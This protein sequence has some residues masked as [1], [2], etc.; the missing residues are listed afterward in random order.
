MG[1]NCGIVGLPNVGKSTL[2]NAL[3][4][5]GADAANY[6]F[7]TID[8]NVGVVTVPDSRLEAL[9]GIYRPQG[10]V[11]TTIEF[12]DIAGLVKGA[13]TGEGLGNKFLSHIRNV[14]AV[15][16][17]VRCF[18]DPDVVHV[19]GRVDPK[20]DIEIVEAELIFKDLETVEKKMT[21]TEKRAR[22]GDKK[23]RAEYDFYSRLKDHLLQAGLA[24]HLAIADE[25]ERFWMRD[26]HLLTNKP[27]MYVCNIPEQEMTVSNSYVSE[28]RRAAKQKNASVVVVS[29]AIEAE[30]AE[31]P[32]EERP[33]FLKGLGQRE[34]GLQKLIRE[35][36]ALLRLVT[37]FTAGSKE[38]HA[39]TVGEGTRA[40]EAAGVVH[41]DFERGFIR[42]EIMKSE[43]LVRMGSEQKVRDHGLL[44]VEGK[45]YSIKDGDVIYFR[46]NV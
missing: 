10:V 23:S 21:D 12:V 45:E 42:A 26:M 44:R 17:V 18:D 27:V 25:P 19:T 22:A 16:H 33:E 13:S 39:W 43:D 14:D 38:V 37:F 36:Y 7:C 3:T 46:F 2:F 41:T 29:A 30:V 20:R 32:V 11:P 9:A 40:P 6:P 1:F 15:A 24:Q 34:S 28:V 5:A 31:L 8:P 4:A 35:G